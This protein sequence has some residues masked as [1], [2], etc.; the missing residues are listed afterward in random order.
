MNGLK[1]PHSLAWNTL[2]NEPLATQLAMFRGTEQINAQ[3]VKSGFR[4]FATVAGAW[5]DRHVRLRRYFWW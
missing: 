2:Y 5:F 4:A 3:D 1:N